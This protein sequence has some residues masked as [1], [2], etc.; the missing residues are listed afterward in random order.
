MPQYLL[1]K[2]IARPA[3]G[4]V[5][6]YAYKPFFILASSSSH[7]PTFNSLFH[8]QTLLKDQKDFKNSF[9]IPNLIRKMQS[10]TQVIHHPVI[11]QT[12]HMYLTVAEVMYAEWG[13]TT[14]AGLEKEVCYRR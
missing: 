2:C 11:Q 14:M 8:S 7:V 3:S 12:E 1:G 10:P 5:E 6:K 4:V 13:L 9:S